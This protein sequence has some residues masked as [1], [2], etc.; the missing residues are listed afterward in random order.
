MSAKDP[1]RELAEQRFNMGKDPGPAFSDLSTKWTNQQNKRAAAS[2]SNSGC[3]GLVFATLGLATGA[4][5]AI[6]HVV[7]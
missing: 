2:G 7:A 5:A 6:Q 1:N 4:F 3:V